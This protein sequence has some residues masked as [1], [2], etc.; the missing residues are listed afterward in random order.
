MAGAGGLANQITLMERGKNRNG[1]VR[2]RS[3][4]EPRFI[5]RF[6]AANCHFL[7]KNW[8][9]LESRIIYDWSEGSFIDLMITLLTQTKIL[10]QSSEKQF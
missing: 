1:W 5:S 10:R 8:L 4:I 7:A 9:L 6:I 3:G 2:K